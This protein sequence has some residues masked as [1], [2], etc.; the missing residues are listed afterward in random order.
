MTFSPAFTVPTWSNVQV[1]LWGAILAP[2]ARTVTAMLRA[3]GQRESLGA[4][5][6]KY[7]RVLNRARWSPLR[8]SRF[9]LGVI[10]DQMIPP[11]EALVLLIDETLERRRGPQIEYSGWFR[12]A[13]RSTGSKVT[14]AMGIRWCCVCILVKVPWC[15]RPWAL[16]FL[17]VPVLSV[18]VCEKLKKKHRGPVC[19][20]RWALRK[21][22]A[23][24]PERSVVLVGDG[25]Y[26]ALGLIATGQKLTQQ[27]SATT[28]VT[29]LR[30]DAGLYDFPQPRQPGERGRNRHKGAALTKLQDRLHQKEE[31]WQDVSVAWY[32]GQNKRL[33]VLSEVCL[34]YKRGSAPVP[35]R[36]V[37]VRA[38]D[39]PHFKAAAYQCSA[40]D[41]T[42]QQILDWV[43]ARWNIEVTF[44]EMRAHL[45][46]ET[47][48]Q[49]SQNA[50][51]RTTPCLFGIFSLVVLIANA[52][53]P[54]GDSLPVSQSSWY[55]KEEATFSDAIAA[56]RE[57]LWQSQN[58][59]PEK[60]KTNTK[61]C[62]KNNITSIELDDWCLIP[63]QMLQSMQ[64]LVCY[65]R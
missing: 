8:L 23:W 30:L 3:T 45:G 25:S 35:I 46:F 44:E 50:I 65:A 28:V 27:G 60:K 16:P 42:P 64:H 59:V 13:V 20:A 53:H 38:V 17:I 31:A 63:K 10:I 36:W 21:V 19:W 24:Q 39:D 37:L 47:Q 22:R 18:K 49:W 4:R 56:V 32:G 41:A 9:L 33:Q 40:V 1:L 5:F 62:P 7:H 12:D 58:W 43:I 2:G 29:G 61:S 6:G 55:T 11:G 57:H 14:F 26:S 54:N 15:R 48:R 52:L 51:N 34:W